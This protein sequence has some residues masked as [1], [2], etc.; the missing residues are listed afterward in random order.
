MMTHRSLGPALG[1]ALLCAG[2]AFAHD[3]PAPPEHEG[4]HEGGAHGAVYTK[5]NY[6]TEVI[7]RPLELPDGMLQ[8]NLGLDINLSSSINN[9]AGDTVVGPFKP[10][11]TPLSAFYGIGGKLQVGIETSGLCL[12]SENCEKVIEDVG[13]EAAFGVIHQKG[14]EMSVQGGLSFSW[15]GIAQADGTV[16]TNVFASLAVGVDVRLQQDQF[17]V[18]AGPKLFFGL[19]HRDGTTN[20]EYLRVPIDF[21]FQA[22][23]HLVL[24]FGMDLNLFLDPPDP[25]GFGDFIGIPL[26][27]GAIYAI[28][29]Q[30]DV[31]AVFT[32]TNLLGKSDAFVFG[33][34]GFDGRQL[35]VFVA[36]RPAL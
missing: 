24:D 14:L 18:R 19:T 36:F 21:Q 17:A 5:D 7:K 25:L 30:F 29:R 15:P 28:N 20:R 23:P 16:A 26:R 13:V 33:P 9:A 8:V 31:G 27:V 32:F 2:A 11:H 22:D 4:A 34:S 1:A 3:E 6:P 12:N 10:V 35:S